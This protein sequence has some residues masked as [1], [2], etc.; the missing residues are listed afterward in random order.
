MTKHF[1]TLFS[2]YWPV[3][4]VFTRGGLNYTKFNQSLKYYI[5]D[6]ESSI[7]EKFLNGEHFEE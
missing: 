5:E 1:D 7:I 4:N 2:I 6:P 3:L